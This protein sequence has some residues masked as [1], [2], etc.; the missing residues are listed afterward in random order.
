VVARFRYTLQQTGGGKI[1]VLVYPLP[2]GLPLVTDPFP[3][4]TSV[5][6]QSGEV[7]VRLNIPLHDPDDDLRTG[8][9]VVDFALFPQGQRESV[10]DVQVRYELI[11]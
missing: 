6:G 5:A 9:I 10:A 4:E 3:A 11:P 7:T 1:G 2:F 8:P